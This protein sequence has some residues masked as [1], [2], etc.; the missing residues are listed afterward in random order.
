MLLN[1]TWLLTLLYSGFDFYKNILN[2]FKQLKEEES[3]RKGNKALAAGDSDLSASTSEDEESDD[4]T[5]E[6]VLN[7]SLPF[8]CPAGALCSRQFKLVISENHYSP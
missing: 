2:R 8:I 4:E 6:E 7:L 1:L 3:K 5:T